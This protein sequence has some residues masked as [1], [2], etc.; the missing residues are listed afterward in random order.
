MDLVNGRDELAE[1]DLHEEEIDSMLK[2]G[3][4]VE[5]VGPPDAATR[6]RFE[7]YRGSSRHYGWRLATPDGRVLASSTDYLTKA[8]A[9][10]A[11]HAVMTAGSG[12]PLVD[13]T[14]G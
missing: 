4:P 10:S 13:R 6:P 8:D 11:V 1:F 3:E 9:L 7:L 2:T 12:A 14:A 5:V